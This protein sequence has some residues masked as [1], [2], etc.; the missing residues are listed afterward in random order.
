MT[1]DTNELFLAARR[2]SAVL[3]RDFA[4]ELGW[5]RLAR[6]WATTRVEAARA[7][8]EA[9]VGCDEMQAIKDALAPQRLSPTPQIDVLRLLGVPDAAIEW[10][11]S[12]RRCRGGR[13]ATSDVRRSRLAGQWSGVS[14]PTRAVLVGRDRRHQCAA[15]PRHDHPP[16]CGELR[17]RMK[18]S[19]AT[20]TPSMI[21]GCDPGKSGALARLD[22]AGRLVDVADMPVVG[23]IISAHLLD[24]IV[25]NWIDP[26][27]DAPYG[28]AV[29]ED[30]HARPGQGSARCFRSVDRS[31]SPKGVGGE[32]PVARYVSPAKWK[33]ALGLS[34]DSWREAV[35]ARS[36]C[37]PEHAKAFA[38]VKDDGRA[39]AALIAWWFGRSEASDDRLSVSVARRSS[40]TPS[41]TGSSSAVVALIAVP[42]EHGAL[43]VGRTHVGR[44][45]RE[46]VP[47]GIA[48][49]AVAGGAVLSGGP[50]LHVAPAVVEPGAALAASWLVRPRGLALRA[51]TRLRLAAAQRGEQH[52]DLCAAVAS[53]EDAALRL[54]VG[55]TWRA[56]SS[57]TVKRPALAWGDRDGATMPLSLPL[58]T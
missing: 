16:T 25:H 33:K 43:E 56:T 48:P 22:H 36:S 30:V 46:V 13:S 12:H 32:R 14:R 2:R 26:L 19:C 35:D 4:Y 1:E 44:E 53:S 24:E 27:A 38:R 50:L 54:A 52:H 45:G 18:L 21:V 15:D 8:G 29:I 11:L 10:V 39:E 23:T 57:M 28:T 47:A 40:R 9:I 49:D 6:R 3:S 37:G 41:A 58:N 34:S 5:L 51:A 55:D 20:R 7:M 17:W 42:R 31:A